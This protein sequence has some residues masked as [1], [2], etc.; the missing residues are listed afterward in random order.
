MAVANSIIRSS[1]TVSP[2]GPQGSQVH[3]DSQA[4]ATGQRSQKIEKLHISSTR[5]IQ[6]GIVNK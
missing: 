6:R 2:K 1:D 3:L 4:L 5:Q